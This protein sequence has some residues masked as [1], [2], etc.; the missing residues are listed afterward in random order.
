MRIACPFGARRRIV[1]VVSVV[2]LAGIGLTLGLVLRDGPSRVLWR[3]V[4]VPG[5]LAASYR[6][7]DGVDAR[8]VRGGTHDRLEVTFD[9]EPVSG[10]LALEVMS[11]DGREL[12]S[13]T[14]AGPE[15]GSV[16]LALT[17]SGAYHVDLR[18]R[19]T[20]GSFDVRYRVVPA[21]AG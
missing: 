6:Y 7:F 9:L 1:I 3:G 18:G 13:R 8:A 11:P 2:V 4:S 14:A 5:H 16:D 10:T 17:T 20:R 21:G 15:R 12:W 19:A